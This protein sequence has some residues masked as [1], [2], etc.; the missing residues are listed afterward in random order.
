M[1]K[2]NEWSIVHE[3]DLEDGTPMAW[4]IELSNGK[5]IWIEKVKDKEYQ[6]NNLNGTKTFAIARTLQG[7]KNWVKNNLLV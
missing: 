6:I 7:A 5:T 1:D 2:I 3:N 4:K